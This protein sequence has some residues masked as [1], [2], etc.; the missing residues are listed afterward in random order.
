MGRTGTTLL[1]PKGKRQGKK[2]LLI[3]IKYKN[4]EGYGP[5]PSSHRSVLELKQLLIDSG[6]G[7]EIDN[8]DSLE[9]NQGE[10]DLLSYPADRI[11]TRFRPR[12]I[13]G[14]D[15]GKI[16]GTELRSCL[17]DPLPLGSNLVAIIDACHSAA[18]LDLDHVFCNRV[19]V[20]WIS[21]GPRR[22][23]SKFGM[24]VRSDAMMVAQPKSGGT[25]WS[26]GLDDISF[27]I[28]RCASPIASCTGFCPPPEVK[29]KCDV[30]VIATC[31]D[32]QQT[33]DDQ[34]G[35]SL[36]L[37]L[38]SLLSKLFITASVIICGYILLSKF[39]HIVIVLFRYEKIPDHVKDYLNAARFYHVD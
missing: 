23:R 20:P 28:T 37:F 27:P 38:I 2:A 7:E 5:L 4:V 6:H 10:H 19:Y 26:F 25:D 8:I 30:I 36:T 15:G 21:K 14:C 16:A 31:R 22:T 13:I 34:D 29:D 3:G 1:Q 18:M 35:T 12:V 24:T 11:F 39:S 9:Y 32:D 33:W 17:V